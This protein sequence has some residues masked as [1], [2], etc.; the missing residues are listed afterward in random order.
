MVAVLLLVNGAPG[1]GKSTLAQRYAD[2][3]ALAL[4]VDIDAIRM[5]LGQ[6]RERDESKLVARNLAV[7]IARAHLVAGHDVVVPQMLAQPEFR[8]QLALVASE[9]QQAFIEVVLTASDDVVVARFRD[10][11]RALAREAEMHPQLDITDDAIATEIPR[12]NAQ[13]VA[14][15]RARDVA[16]I[17]TTDGSE[18]ACRALFDAIARQCDV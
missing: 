5:Q 13:L 11:R 14:D 12:L 1:V 2:E 18:P 4:I 3:H 6:W 9:V 8:E 7:A 15:A 16:V 17:D 10:R